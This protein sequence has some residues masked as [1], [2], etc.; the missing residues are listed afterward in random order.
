MHVVFMILT[1]FLSILGFAFIL[2]EEGGEFEA[3]TH[4]LV[5][6]FSLIAAFIQPV[7]ALAR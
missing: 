4:P 3:E 5:G 2:V 6:L 7:M 1:V